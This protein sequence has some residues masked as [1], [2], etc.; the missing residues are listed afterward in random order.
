MTTFIE[1]PTEDGDLIC[2]ICYEKIGTTNDEGEREQPV[3]LDCQHVFGNIC[4]DFWLTKKTRCPIC[5]TIVTGHGGDSSDDSEFSGSDDSRS[6]ESTD[7]EEN[8]DSD[9]DDAMGDDSEDDSV[10]EDGHD[11]NASQAS[12]NSDMSS[13]SNASDDSDISE[14]SVDTTD[15]GGGSGTHGM[16]EN[17]FETQP[18]SSVDDNRRTLTVHQTINPL[19]AN[20]IAGGLMAGF[21]SGLLNLASVIGRAGASPENDSMDE[22]HWM[23]EI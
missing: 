20:T 18:S 2:V 16:S 15:E 17:D 12:E 4:L 3:Q 10:D 13:L 19:S 8:G 23:D 5:R 9:S 22:D 7:S 21:A 1:I 14:M 6:S 11:D